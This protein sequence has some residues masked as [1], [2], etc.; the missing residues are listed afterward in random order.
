M[1]SYGPGWDDDLP[2]LEWSDM[3]RDTCALVHGRA[4]EYDPIGRRWF[5]S[6]P[7]KPG[8]ASNRERIAAWERVTDRESEESLRRQAAGLRIISDL[9]ERWAGVPRHKSMV[10][11]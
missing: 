5:R 10:V 2:P 6:R 1:N 4:L 8:V 7:L 11:V 9:R 3:W